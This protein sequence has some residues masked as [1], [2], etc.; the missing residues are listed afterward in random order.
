VSLHMMWDGGWQVH[1]CNPEWF[2][3]TELGPHCP[4]TASADAATAH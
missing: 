3:N 1:D 4:L 2:G